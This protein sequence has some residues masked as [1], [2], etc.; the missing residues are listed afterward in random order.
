MKTTALFLAFVTSSLLIAS[1]PSRQASGGVEAAEAPIL[2]ERAA[3]H[4]VLGL[5]AT[6]RLENGELTVTTN[7]LVRV[8]TGLNYLAEGGGF[9]PAVAEFEL[10]EGAAVA[11]R[12]QH[13]VTLAWN[14]NS[15]ETV[16]LR[17]PDGRLLT[18]HVHGLAYYDAATGE[19]VL[20]ATV[21][22]SQGLLVAPNQVLYPAAFRGSGVSADIR[23]TYTLDTFEQDI[24][25]REAPAGPEA[26]GL[27]PATTR[28]EVWTEFPE[29][30]TPTVTAEKGIAAE[31]AEDV[32]EKPGQ[33]AEL[34]DEAVDFGT[35]RL[36]TGRAFR[37][38][39]HAD[40]LAIVAKQWVRTEDSR[41]FLVET[42]AVEQLAE[43]LDKLPPGAGGAALNRQKNRLQALRMLP[44]RERETAA[45]GRIQRPDS[46]RLL[47]LLD[48]P[49]VVLDWVGLNTSQTNY[50]FR[51][52][53]TYWITGAVQTYGTNTTFEGGTV[54]KFTNNVANLALTVNTPLTW[55]GSLYRPVV[56]TAQDDHSVGQ[57]I[58][59][60]A[61]AATNAYYA[62]TA[63]VLDAGT[64]A[65][66]NFQLAHLR[67][68]HA[69]TAIEL[70]QKSG[71]VLSHL[72]L[73]N[74]GTGI[75][76]TATA[77][78]VRNALFCNVLTNFSG[79]AS[80]FGVEHLTSDGASQLKTGSFMNLYL[81]NS[82]LA[83]VT[84][85]QPYSGTAVAE[86]AGHGWFQQVLGGAHY[87]SD[88]SPL[89]NV[90]SVAINPRLAADLI[91]LTTHPPLHATN[92]F[93]VNTTLQPQAVRDTDFP[94]LGYHYPPLDY[95]WSNLSVAS[96]KS[97]TLLNG[98][99]VGLFGS[100]GL[101]VNGTFSSIGQPQA[102]NRLT[103]LTTVQENL[104]GII[105]NT[106]T[107]TLRASGG[108]ALS[109]RFTDISFLAAPN[110]GREFTP[111]TVTTGDVTV[112]DCQL[113][114]VYWNSI[115]YSTLRTLM[116]KNSLLDR[117]T[118]SWGQ[119]YSIYPNWLAVTLQNCL[120]SR[121]AVGLTH[122]GDYY[123]SWTLYDN[124]FDNATLSL[125]EMSP[126][127]NGSAL[128]TAGNNGFIATANAFGGSN[129]R[130]NLLRDF[131]PGP[132]GAFY[133]PASG[134]TNSLASLRNADAVRT[135]AGV[136]LTH[137]TTTQ[138]Q[139]KDTGYLDLGYHYVALRKSLASA[140][141]GQEQGGGGWRYMSAPAG[142][143]NLSNLPTFGIP[144]WNPEN[145]HYNSAWS[146]TA[147][148]YTGIWDDSQ[149]PGWNYDSVRVWQAPSS[150]V[151]TIVSMARNY[152]AC[153][154]DG[155][156]IRIIRN[157]LP[158]E[159]WR[160]VPGNNTAVALDIVSPISLGDLLG[161]Q[162]NKKSSAAC[163][164]TIWDPLVIWDTPNDQDG[165]GLADYSE[166][167]D[168]NGS[169]NPS[170]E[171]KPD[172]ADTDDDGMNDGEE[173]ALGRN[174][175]SADATLLL[176]T[177]SL[178]LP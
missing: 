52:D 57:K 94:D 7:R 177:P 160:N 122:A 97:L 149:H 68:S 125:T 69:K 136:G 171:T 99:A 62:T 8:A 172:D 154:S 14:A 117:T 59:N 112:Q 19:A 114:G 108:T 20:I 107:F 24:I 135:P 106:G 40:T 161:F 139:A 142:N 84:N 41:N 71:H 63:L 128:T 118:L 30:P 157:G 148:K 3:H 73:V 37:A 163:D 75:A 141:F 39:D 173:L 102:L 18:S 126:Y 25:L 109:L 11:W 34:W 6:N 85:T 22:D 156:Q 153:G 89:R 146:A 130:T 5:V 21:Q 95:V 72:Q 140:S 133:Y 15:A 132:L 50:V 86:V 96:G 152:A 116:L 28:L 101:T 134:A 2:L 124:L 110:A 23:Y 81:T 74:C 138:D 67:V 91:G 13:K 61:Q 167:A 131:V 151:V 119:G 54:I 176:F 113:R 47:A 1:L 16:Q 66:T 169:Y 51:G 31:Q 64:N 78:S 93:S 165:D 150:G 158:L 127:P 121:S 155:V 53:E 65:V 175:R 111:Y 46:G 115:G 42:V 88:G 26:F 35:L 55:E 79:S 77:F 29:A 159:S 32:S 178:R 36:G 166:D 145:T 92:G 17:V 38:D 33:G 70:K 56:L 10:I 58:G 162:L 48:R 49:G 43:A 168:G 174:P 60:A 90:G 100:T 104:A 120:V 80:T 170:S 83:N 87:L 9:S 4:D 144:D 143:T 45:R 76:P 129:N 12:G 103:L 27:N 105:T 137:Y 82:I 164:A 98:V 147:D 44:R 123:G